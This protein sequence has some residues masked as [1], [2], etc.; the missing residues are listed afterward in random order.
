MKAHDNQKL[1][2]KFKKE[3][4]VY[5]RDFTSVIIDITGPFSYQIKKDYFSAM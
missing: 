2:R 5:A 1:H 3:D 4:K